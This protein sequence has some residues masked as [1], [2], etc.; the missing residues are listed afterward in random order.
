[1]GRT[2]VYILPED[3]IEVNPAVYLGYVRKYGKIVFLLSPETYRSLQPIW[4]DLRKLRS[5]NSKPPETQIEE[6][7][8]KHGVHG[9]D[10]LLG[11]VSFFIL[12]MSNSHKVTAEKLSQEEV[13]LTFSA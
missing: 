1:M 12:A 7:L 9:S 11:L 8:S 6:F 4:D 10:K 3:E 5:E 13:C 2:H